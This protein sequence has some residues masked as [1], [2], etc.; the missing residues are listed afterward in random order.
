MTD[1]HSIA[2]AAAD[3][4]TIHHGIEEEDNDDADERASISSS[5][6][7]YYPSSSHRRRRPLPPVP[8]LRFE[9]S[10]LGSIAPANG[11][12]WKIALITAKDQML[13]PLLQGLG[14]NL[15]VVGWRSWNRGVRFHGAGLGG[16]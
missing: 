1:P 16:E 15:V 14:F 12:W 9:Q 2:V 6:L 11:V 13:M 4:K 8:D 5:I 10:Y 3:D 7:D